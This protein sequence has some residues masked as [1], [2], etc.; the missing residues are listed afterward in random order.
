VES[1][2]STP[3][4]WQGRAVSWNHKPGASLFPSGGASLD[5]LRLPKPSKDSVWTT[6]EKHTQDGSHPTKIH[7][8]WI[9]LRENLQETIDFP[10]KY[11]AF[12]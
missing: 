2:L 12:L 9:G 10:M 1:H 4:S 11:G 3:N 5:T 7:N 6:L 8:Q